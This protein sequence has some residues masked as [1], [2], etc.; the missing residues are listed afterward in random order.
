M[1]S[2]ITLCDRFPLRLDGGK[3]I[4]CP[5]SDPTTFTIAIFWSKLDSIL[6]LSNFD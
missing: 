4:A 5:V 3:K 2:F 6:Q 1:R